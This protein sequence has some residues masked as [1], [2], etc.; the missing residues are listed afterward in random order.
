MCSIFFMA[1]MA[2]AVVAIEVISTARARH[3]AAAVGRALIT[4]CGSAAALGLLCTSVIFSCP[5]GVLSLFQT[6][7][8]VLPDAC[9]YATARAIST[10]FALVAIVCQAAFR[11]LLDVR[12]PLLVV[13][14]ASA[15]N[16]VL[17]PL[18]IFTFD[19][20]IAGA[21]WATAIAQ[22]LGCAAF[23]FALWRRRDEFGLPQ[24]LAA[25]VRHLRDAR[26]LAASVDTPRSCE[27]RS[28]ANSWHTTP[29]QNCEQSPCTSTEMMRL[30]GLQGD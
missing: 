17:D 9:A 13:A 7:A 30:R 23:F 16:L 28:T 29:E 27:R 10:P 12:T 24:A 1:Y 22:I 8:E 18:L 25:M 4:S 2:L 20:G 3:G 14:F 21:A 11:A 26:A 19:M 5:E 15:I 6:P